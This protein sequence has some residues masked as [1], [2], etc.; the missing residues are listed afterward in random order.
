MPGAAGR[1]R[2]GFGSGTLYSLRIHSV[3]RD[4]TKCLQNA[5]AFCAW[6]DRRPPEVYTPIA[7]NICNLSLSGKEDWIREIV[8]CNAQTTEGV[9]TISPG[10]LAASLL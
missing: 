7:E 2:V 10:G 9:R 6:P 4:A 8:V 3:A 5:A 1:Q